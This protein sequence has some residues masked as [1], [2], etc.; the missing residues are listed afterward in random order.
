[1]FKS[2]RIQLTKTQFGILTVLAMAFLFA[3]ET[4]CAGT[5]NSSDLL[6]FDI[7]GRNLYNRPLF[8]SEPP[9]V[10]YGGSLPAFAVSGTWYGGKLGNL[11]LVIMT[12][13]GNFAAHQAQN[14][15]ASY[16]GLALR[17]EIRDRRLKKGVLRLEVFPSRPRGCLAHLVA[18]KLPIGT[19]LAWVYGGASGQYDYKY[20]MNYGSKIPILPLYK[21]KYKKYR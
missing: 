3:S 1:M 9:F 8:G 7:T 4:I 17:Y 20:P 12:K 19:N 6:Q 2:I 5:P 13:D 21:V 16:D 10:T 18:E 14:V 15:T 11:H